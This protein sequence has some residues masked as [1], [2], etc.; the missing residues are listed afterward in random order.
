MA[1]DFF[2]SHKQ[3]RLHLAKK[4]AGEGSGVVGEVE[5]QPAAFKLFHAT[6]EPD[7]ITCVNLVGG[8]VVFHPIALDAE[9]LI[10]H[11]DV[12]CRAEEI[13]LSRLGTFGT[14]IGQED[15]LLRERQQ[16]RQHENQHDV[17]SMPEIT[18]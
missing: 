16:K 6:N 8:A 11:H 17:W 4:V 13:S 10:C 2:G 15:L 3:S 1:L 7:T 14:D 12:L 5:T 18:C 9:V